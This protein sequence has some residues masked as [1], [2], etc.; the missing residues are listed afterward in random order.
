MQRLRHPVG[1]L[2]YVVALKLSVVSRDVKLPA[3]SCIRAQVER[4]ARMLVIPAHSCSV[5]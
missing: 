2:V 4:T 3:L 5:L 1:G